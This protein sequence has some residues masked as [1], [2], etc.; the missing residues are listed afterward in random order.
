VECASVGTTHIHTTEAHVRGAGGKKPSQG[1][2]AQAN[3]GFVNDP[4]AW[5]M[6]I[7]NTK[8]L[9]YHLSIEVPLIIF[10]MLHFI[11]FCSCPCCVSRIHTHV[12][13]L[14]LVRCPI[15]TFLDSIVDILSTC[16]LA[17]PV[18]YYHLSWTSETS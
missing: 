14:S 15:V 8:D 18:W 9:I 3:L 16:T 10:V 12:E 7:G 2:S 11:G 4:S 6:D 5:I 17:F 1:P 13:Q